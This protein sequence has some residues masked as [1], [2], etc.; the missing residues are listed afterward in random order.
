MNHPGLAHGRDCGDGGDQPIISCS[1]IVK[2]YGD[3]R[4]LKGVTLDVRRGDVVSIIGPSGCG[5]STF[6]RCLN[7]LESFD[8]GGLSILGMDLSAAGRDWRLWRK[9][10]TRV[11]MVFQHFNLFPHLTIMENLTIA[12]RRVLRISLEESRSRAIEHLAQVGLEAKAHA[13]PSQLSGGQKQRVAIARGL[14][15]RPDVLLFDEPTSALDPELV[16]EVMATL[17][18][19][20]ETGMTML[21]V[22]HEMKFAR[23]ASDRVVFFKAGIV[24]EQGDPKDVFESPRSPALKAFLGKAV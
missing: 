11:G 22:T 1:G 5:K 14:C 23:D 3:N 10:R 2:S 24:E 6:L 12:P 9:V 20:S 13:Y 16:E 4:V 21:V 17:R 19:L 7:G 18:M 15:M 8:A